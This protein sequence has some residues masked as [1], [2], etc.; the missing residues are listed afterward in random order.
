MLSSLFTTLDIKRQSEDS[1]EV[2]PARTVSTQST[3]NPVSQREHQ[4]RT[5]FVKQLKCIFLHKNI[6]NKLHKHLR[7][8]IVTSVTPCG[9]DA[10]RN[11]TI[12]ILYDMLRCIFFFTLK[13]CLRY[14]K[15]FYL[16]SDRSPTTLH[17][18]PNHP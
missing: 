15:C 8:S 11:M 12:Y 5:L 2:V 6:N 3:E 1:D 13:T 17:A 9:Q 7:L 10:K 18:D 14:G 16:G 4:K